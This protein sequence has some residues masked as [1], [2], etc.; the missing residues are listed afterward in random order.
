M[1][2]DYLKAYDPTEDNKW[3][4]TYSNI[5]YE[6][7]IPPTIAY[8]SKLLHSIAKEKDV[9]KLKILLS[10]Y[11]KIPVIA[12]CCTKVVF[13]EDDDLVYCSYLG[14]ISYLNWQEGVDI[15]LEYDMFNL[16][17]L[18]AIIYSS[19]VESIE[20]NRKG[21]I[22]NKHGQTLLTKLL[23]RKHHPLVYKLM[24]HYF[25]AIGWWEGF[26]ECLQY[27]QDD[28]WTLNECYEVSTMDM[29][30]D[31]GH[32]DPYD[33]II[34]G[35]QEILLMFK[36]NFKSKLEELI[37]RHSAFKDVC[38]GLLYKHDIEAYFSLPNHYNLT[39]SMIMDERIC[40]IISDEDVLVF[41]SDMN[42]RYN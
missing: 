33:Y 37:N 4:Y 24:Y 9:N 10:Y 30:L 29:Q 8:C 3:T 11:Y 19:T 41:V 1:N 25:C 34:N 21:E 23:Q 2:I 26:E 28:W 13:L 27:R 5:L 15:A 14:Y 12:Y 20:I 6:E 17:E 42:K 35:N 40:S 16:H 39:D 7:D 32:L 22:L 18:T 36:R 31:Y 38:S